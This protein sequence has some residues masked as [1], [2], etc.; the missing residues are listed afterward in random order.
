[1][2]A[3]NDFSVQLA[4]RF[5]SQSGLLRIERQ[6]SVQLASSSH[7]GQRGRVTS[8]V[9]A[10]SRGSKLKYDDSTETRAG[11]IRPVTFSP[12]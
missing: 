5:R 3:L 12:G 10:S 11:A 1:M 4:G 7:V 8:H 2:A 6:F 9:V